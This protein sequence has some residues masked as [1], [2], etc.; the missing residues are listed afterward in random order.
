VIV[1]V[2]GSSRA[3]ECAAAIETKTHQHALIVT[4]LAMAA[5]CLKRQEAE[6]VVI[7]ESLQQRDGGIDTLMAKVAMNA[8]PIYVN[9]SL[10]GAE[11]VAIEVVCALQRLTREKSSCMRAAAGEL[12][13]RL[14]GEVTAILLN[15]ELA[16]REPALATGTAQKLKVIREMAEKMRNSLEEPPEAAPATRAK[17]RLVER[18]TAARSGR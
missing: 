3:E 8:V 15:A 12:R 1:L 2:S 16:L 13:H 4:S 11:R 10:H 14:R 9:L 7:D 18:E 5:D 6:A 17:L